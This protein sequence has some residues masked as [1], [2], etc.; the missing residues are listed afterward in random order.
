LNQLKFAP[1]RFAALS[2][3]VARCWRTL[4]ASY[5]LPHD[6]VSGY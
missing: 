6:V 3:M 1:A 4:D 5:S 2:R